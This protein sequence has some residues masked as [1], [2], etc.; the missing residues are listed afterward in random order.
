MNDGSITCLPTTTTFASSS[1]ATPQIRI[2]SAAALP[3]IARM[4]MKEPTAPASNNRSASP[5]SATGEIHARH[6]NQVVVIAPKAIRP[7]SAA[8]R[9]FRQNTGSAAVTAKPSA[10]IAGPQVQGRVCGPITTARIKAATRKMAETAGTA[11]INAEMLK[12]ETLKLRDREDEKPPVTHSTVNPSRDAASSTNRG[13]IAEESQ[14]LID[15]PPAGRRGLPQP[16]RLGSVPAA[17]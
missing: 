7:K 12:T 2:R 8:K 4:L 16:I 3:S 6:A 5:S 15:F 14:N 17:S 11:E 13:A 10:S 1:R 9:P